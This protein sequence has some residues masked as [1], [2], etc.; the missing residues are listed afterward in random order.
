MQQNVEFGQL[1][2]CG[3]CSDFYTEKIWCPI[4]ILML[5]YW[6]Q[7]LSVIWYV[8]SAMQAALPML[9]LCSGPHTAWVYN[10]ACLD[11]TSSKN[12]KYVCAWFYLSNFVK[13]IVMT[14]QV[15]A[16]FWQWICTKKKFRDFLIVRLTI[17]ERQI[18]W[19]NSSHSRSVGLMNIV[20]NYLVNEIAHLHLVV[21]VASYQTDT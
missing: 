2:Y 18:F 9:W 13:K 21:F 17:F 7:Y 20:T 16:I 11:Q 19:S 15:S 14:M 8:C 3:W 12:T 1:W 6:W 4:P 10:R 5:V